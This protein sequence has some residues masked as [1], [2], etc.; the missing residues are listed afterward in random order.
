LPCACPVTSVSIAAARLPIRRTRRLR[1]L[2]PSEW[3]CERHTRPE[4]ND[5]VDQRN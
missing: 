3:R 1:T 2:I 4:R 5:Y